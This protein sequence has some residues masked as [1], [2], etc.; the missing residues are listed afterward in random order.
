MESAMP[1]PR[2]PRDAPGPSPRSRA[3]VEQGAPALTEEPLGDSRVFNA[4]S[5][6]ARLHILSSLTASEKTVAELARELRL[7]RITVRYHLNQLLNQGLVEETRGAATGRVGR[8][9]LR[10]R[11]TQEARVGGFPPRRYELLGRMALEVLRET[12]GDRRCVE[13]LREKG[14]LSDETSAE[15]EP[16]PAV[17]EG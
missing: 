7:H 12:L 5:S 1:R 8:P 4:L 14:Y 10:Y 16:E 13:R 6:T 3:V 2:V 11:A 17:A 15:L 9:P